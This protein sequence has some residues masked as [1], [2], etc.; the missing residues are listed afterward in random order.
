[1]EEIPLI[2]EKLGALDDTARHGL[3]DCFGTHSAEEVAQW[4]ANGTCEL[5][6]VDG[7]SFLVTQTNERTLFVW[8]YQGRN[9]RELAK[10]L[11]AVARKNDC[12]AIRFHTYRAGFLRMLERFGAQLTDRENNG[13]LVV[14]VPTW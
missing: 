13:L 14:E 2:F 4:I 5:W 1:M 9:V 6:R 10:C 11:I 12:D 7:D 3:R 8:C